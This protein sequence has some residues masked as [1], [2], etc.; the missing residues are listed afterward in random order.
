[1]L[2]TIIVNIE[3]LCEDED[4]NF[5]KEIQ[6]IKSKAIELNQL[7]VNNG[8]E[9]ILFSTLKQETINFL[10]NKSKKDANDI[11]YFENSTF[12]SYNQATPI[13][14]IYI[15]II[16]ERKF[17]FNEILLIQ[18]KSH[19]KKL[20]KGINTLTISSK[21]DVIN[22]LTKKL[23]I[24][25]NDIVNQCKKY[26][27]ES[28]FFKKSS[29]L[30]K[31]DADKVPDIKTIRD[32]AQAF[33]KSRTAMAYLKTYIKDLAPNDNNK[34]YGY[35]EFLQ[36]H[37]SIYQSSFFKSSKFVTKLLKGEIKNMDD[38]HQY[39]E[40]NKNS[41]TARLIKSQATLTK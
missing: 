33:P 19:A 39:A 16:N 35:K 9:L 22:E 38:V 25:K 29:F 32:Y 23:E 2:K 34:E 13:N 41:T 15:H 24:T 11:D 27:Q 21:K 31:V 37:F 18:E 20:I 4:L 1:M 28:G 36:E 40:D 12:Y 26:Y 17:S 5:E 10:L 8:A 14:N 3:L 30:K 6:N 7:C